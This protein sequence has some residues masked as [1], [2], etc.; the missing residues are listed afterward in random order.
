M[1]TTAR[2]LPLAG[3]RVLD[4]ARLLPGPWA[5]QMLGEF[6]ADVIKVEQPVTGD[7]SRHNHPVLA[8]NSYYFNSMNGNKRGITLNLQTPEGRAVAHR[9][10]RD[11]DVVIESA[12]PGNAAR[13]GLD[14]ATLRAV[15]RRIIVCGITGFGRTGPLAHIAGHDLIMQGLTGQMGTGLAQQ[16]PPPPPGFLAA[17]FAGGLFCV[18]GVQA[19]L[20]QR[21][22]TGEGC[23]IDLAMFD[24]QFS[25]GMLP[26]ASAM[27]RRMGHSGEPRIEVFG[28][29]PRYTTYLSRDGKPVAVALLETSAWRNFCRS[30][31][32][33]DLVPQDESLADRLSAHPEHADKYRVALAEYC[34]AHDWA[35]IMQRLE[36]A[37]I[38]I[39]PICTPDEAVQLDHVA[40]RG[41]INEIAHPVEGRM[42]HLVNPLA[43]AGLAR[44]SHIP[45][46]GL[47]QHTE[48]VLGE[49]GYD[50]EAIAT[51][52]GQG[53]I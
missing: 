14:Y 12:R 21:E 18:I 20:A 49:Y 10:V 2:P 36:A 11:A 25:M 19:A 8:E 27:A 3:I 48:E 7:P 45:S 24:A 51:L 13:L 38:A 43:R 26:L 42:Q 9:L 50:A 22:K 40:A 29:N 46:P 39:A 23:E 44:A 34:A 1:T 32:R 41:L 52:R 4:F 15:N 16:N 6:G 28:G 33:E 17:D 35:E 53:A 37:G 30:I 47:G 5:S 31:G